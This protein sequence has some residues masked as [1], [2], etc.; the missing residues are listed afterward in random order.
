MTIKGERS[1]DNAQVLWETGRSKTA[2]M[3]TEK[4]E[5]AFTLV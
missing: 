3:K 4:T 2:K 1:R 5:H